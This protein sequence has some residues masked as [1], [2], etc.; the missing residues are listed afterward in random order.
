LVRIQRLELELARAQ[1]ALAG[2]YEQQLS[3]RRVAHLTEELAQPM[4]LVMGYAEMLPADLGDMGAA[5]SDCDIIAE[6]VKRMARTLSLLRRLA[7]SSGLG[8]PARGA[9]GPAEKAP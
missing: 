2:L 6:Q 3:L 4:T 5:R 1:E 8:P 7:P 9:P